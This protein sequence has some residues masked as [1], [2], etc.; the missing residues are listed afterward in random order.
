ME[1]WIHNGESIAMNADQTLETKGVVEWGYDGGDI[2]SVFKGFN[3]Q[4][5]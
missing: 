4:Q 1:I 3:H 2:A 5:W